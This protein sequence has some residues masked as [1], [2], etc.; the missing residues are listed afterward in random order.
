MARFKASLLNGRQRGPQ[1]AFGKPP[2]AVLKKLQPKKPTYTPEEAAQ[3]LIKAV[4]M[5]EIHEIAGLLGLTFREAYKERA[6]LY[7]VR[8]GI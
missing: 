7:G 8:F 2:P 3:L 1:P 6:R 5:D 4:T